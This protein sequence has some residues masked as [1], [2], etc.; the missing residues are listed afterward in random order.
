MW[1]HRKTLE[2]SIAGG[3]QEII[4][5]LKE[6]GHSFEKCLKI[7]VKYHRYE[8]TNWLLEN[9]KCKPVSLPLCIK[10]Y[11]I[12]AFL[13]FLEHEHSID[14]TDK[15]E[16]TSLHSAFMIGHL[17]IVQ[18]LIEK[19]SDIEAKDK[20]NE[21]PLHTVCED[22]EQLEDWKTNYACPMKMSSF[23][24]IFCF[25]I[26]TFFNE[27]LN[28]WKMTISTCNMKRSFLI[29]IFCSNISTFFNKILNNW[30]I[31]IRTC[32]WRRL[33]AHS[34]LNND[35]ILIPSFSIMYWI[36]ESFSSFI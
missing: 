27:I 4:N 18:Y 12:D 32:I 2:Y 7:S 1:N 28:N 33:I 24:F 17:P 30:K 31:T 16:W 29:F 26:S 21:T 10:Y 36:L 22:I 15:Y 5:I 13:Y 3:N 14:E 11:N 6:K 9:Y 35:S 19:G 23:I 8:L 34:L 20:N 25:N